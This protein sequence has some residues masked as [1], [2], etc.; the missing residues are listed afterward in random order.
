MGPTTAIYGFL[1]SEWDSLSK[2]YTHKFI[3]SSPTYTSA[4]GEY[5]HRIIPY[6]Q[7]RAIQNRFRNV[8]DIVEQY[9]LSQMEKGKLEF[10]TVIMYPKVFD[11][12]EK[13]LEQYIDTHRLPVYIYILAWLYDFHHIHIQIIANHINPAYCAIIYQKSG[14]QV[15]EAV[16]N[17]LKGMK[18]EYA[19]MLGT[20]SFYTP[21]AMTTHGLEVGQKIFTLTKNEF[22]H[23][24]NIMYSVWR[25]FYFAHLCSDLVANFVTPNFPIMNRYFYIQNSDSAIFDNPSQHEKYEQ[26]GIA[27][28][29]SELLS[30]VDKLNFVERKKSN[31]YI[32]SKFFQLSHKIG[33][34]N[35]FAQNNIQLIDI[36][37]CLTME[38]TWR[39]IRDIFPLAANSPI[40]EIL[41]RFLTD[42]GIFRGGI[43]GFLYSFY[44][45]N[46]KVGIIH[47]D[48]HLNNATLHVFPRA[49][50]DPENSN[51]VYI[52][53]DN[54]RP[55]PY[56][57]RFNKVYPTIIDM[58]RAITN[59]V[60]LLEQDFGKRFTEMY[61]KDQNQRVMRSILNYFPIAMERHKDKVEELVRNNFDLM[62]RLLT[63]VDPYAI[64]KNLEVLFEHEVKKYPTLK[65]NPA[66]PQFLRRIVTMSE[67]AFTTKLEEIISG[68]ITTPEALEWPCLTIIKEL[69]TDE[70][71]TDASMLDGKTIVDIFT[72]MNPLKYS[73]RRYD[74]MHEILRPEIENNARK[75]F[76][77]DITDNLQALE[78]F[79]RDESDKRNMLIR[80]YQG[81][82]GDFSTYSPWMFE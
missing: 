4:D 80:Q 47:A 57:F 66:I 46:S 39:T 54:G 56:A 27:K 38:H 71:I 19:R 81:D 44:A 30:E 50:Q 48:M 14:I 1:Y 26:A 31:N 52:V 69:F 18:I 12:N 42:Y 55:K 45:A 77:R 33:K 64:C 60:K 28:G 76:G 6:S 13:I 43:F 75:K 65:V 15:Y 29:I 37:L 74:T 41:Q 58:S 36:S 23:T 25:E 51:T 16:V 5:R 17:E 10:N 11:G 61:M 21:D 63:L 7:L 73:I 9:I 34:A 62:F 2:Q 22:I 20:I 40:K 49:L 32:N 3:C 79:Q 24:G 59:N 53:N 78:D 82:T 35:T 68:K 8:F 72:M 70:E 67:I